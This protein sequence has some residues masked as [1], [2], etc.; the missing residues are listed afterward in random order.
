MGVVNESSEAG[1]FDAYEPTAKFRAVLAVAESF[2]G[3][4]GVSIDAHPG[5]LGNDAGVV[6]NRT[7]R[8]VTRAILGAVIPEGDLAAVV[9]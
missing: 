7:F 1:G 6:V 3:E 4:F 5:G 2:R 8:V 9:T